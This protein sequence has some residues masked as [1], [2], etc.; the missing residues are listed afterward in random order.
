MDRTLL[1]IE[2]KR[3]EFINQLILETS[4]MQTNRELLDT[5]LKKVAEIIDIDFGY[6][7]SY[8]K[9]EIIT[10]YVEGQ[11]NLPY[12]L[13]E[14][15]PNYRFESSE[16]REMI[17]KRVLIVGQEELLIPEY[18]CFSRKYRFSTV[19]TV[20]IGF[21]STN[22][23]K[24]M[25][26][27]SRKGKDEVLEHVPLLETIGN[28]LWML[29]Q[30]QRIYEKYQNNIVRTEK[31]RAL[32]ELA[33]GIIHDFNNLLTTILGFSQIILTRELEEEVKEFVNIIHK[34]ALDGKKIVERLQ[35]FNRG[36]TH[37]E[38]GVYDINSI[39][40][41]SIEM[42]RPRWKYFYEYYGNELKIEKDL[43]A[44][45]KIFC[46]EHEIREVIINLLSNAMD[47]MENGGVLSVKTY[48]EEDKVV[49][50][51]MDT[52]SGIP[53][54]IREE[55]FEPFC[56]TKGI[57]G[58][59]L[60]LSIVKDIINDHKGFIE[61]ESK[62]GEGTTFR[63]YFNRFFEDD[64]L[65]KMPRGE[66][67][68]NLNISSNVNI[69][70]VDDIPEVSETI[71]Q[72]FKTIGLNA[73]IE[74]QSKNVINRLMQEKYDI[75]ICDLAMPELNGIDLSKL[76]KEKFPDIKF[77]IITGWPGKIKSEGY[78]NI[79]YVLRKPLTIED[80]YSAI[81]TVLFTPKLDVQQSPEV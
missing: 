62:I 50:E 21:D 3:L 22:A 77:I 8:T 23:N 74:S 47:A 56:S 60:G 36:R 42:V 16:I 39:V 67:S 46:V 71:V 2:N 54:E 32:G 57:K 59:G 76:V 18:K 49:V 6:I 70:V 75:I 28:T 65:E 17:R 30:K 13:L 15:V 35:N 14:E 63:I 12:G 69:L 37:T 43:R 33:G 78:N 68:H 19:I 64:K 7:V 80:L 10:R 29:M 51:I 61:L 53:E 66:I 48:D 44:K 5:S 31:F 45:S 34:S 72:M 1:K 38:K 20:P 55:I 81:E 41:S 73:Q 25:L 11:Y 58:T 40:E 24:L 4:Y 26:L 9:N 52:G 27:F 79:D